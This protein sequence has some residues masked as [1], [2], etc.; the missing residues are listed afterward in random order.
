MLHNDNYMT[1]FSAPE[2]TDCALVTCNCMR[3]TLALR[4]NVCLFFYV[5]R[6]VV[7]AALFGC[8]MAVST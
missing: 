3:V 6:S 4:S 2:H 5:H 1:L 8:Y 7:L